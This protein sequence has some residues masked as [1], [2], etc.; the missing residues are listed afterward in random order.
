[1]R[2]ADDAM[3]SGHMFMPAR[4]VQGEAKEEER[5]DFVV[6]ASVAMTLTPRPQKPSRTRGLSYSPAS[7]QHARAQGMLQTPCFPLPMAQAPGETMGHACTFVGGP[8][9]WARFPRRSA[10]LGV[11]VWIL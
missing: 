1:M 6:R 8:M 10:W 2:L 5:G 4:V 9:A 7:W 3:S 11:V